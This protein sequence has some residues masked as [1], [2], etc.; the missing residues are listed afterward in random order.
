MKKLIFTLLITI[1]TG[2]N[3]QIMVV[4]ELETESPENFSATVTQWM[5]AVKT[6]LEM[7]DARAYIFEEPGTK[8]AVSTVF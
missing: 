3:A 7:D 6:G 1:S 2:M 5:S 8:N 4:N